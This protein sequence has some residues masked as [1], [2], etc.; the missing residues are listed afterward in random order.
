MNTKIPSAVTKSLKGLGRQKSTVDRTASNAVGSYKKTE[1]NSGWS[2]ADL[3]AVAGSTALERRPATA[4]H[5]VSL[6]EWNP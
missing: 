1:Q 4:N 5:P 3:V 6:R 2:E